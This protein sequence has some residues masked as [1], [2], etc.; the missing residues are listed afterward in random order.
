[1]STRLVDL[2]KQDL[3]AARDNLARARCAARGCDPRK[4][5]GRSG[6]TLNQIIS[7]YKQWES[8]ALDALNEALGTSPKEGR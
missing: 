5:W 6:Q 2:A 8:D 3:G 7:G 4:E 1:M